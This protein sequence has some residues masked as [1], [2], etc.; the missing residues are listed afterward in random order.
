MIVPEKRRSIREIPVPE[1]RRRS[2]LSQTT[3][4]HIHTNQESNIKESLEVFKNGGLP[5]NNGNNSPRKRRNYLIASI[6]IILA[7][8][9]L[10][11]S[12]FSGAV[13]SYTPRIVT[14]SFSEDKFTAS[15]TGN[16]DLLYNVVKLSADMGEEVPASGEE[17]VEKKAS[18]V[19]TVY[20]KTAQNQRLR[21]TTR[22]A[23]PDGK[24]YQIEEAISVPAMK[25]V[26]GKETPGS[27]DVTVYS[28]K[29]GEEYNIGLSDFT[30]PGLK[31]TS[32]SE[33]VYARSQTPMS[34][35]FV[36]TEKVVSESDRL[37]AEASLETKL[38]E[39]LMSEAQKQ[40]PEGFILIPSLSAISFQA[41]PRT[42]SASGTGASVN[43]R[44]NISG[45]MFK[46][47]DLSEHL[48]VG[49]INRAFNESVEI[50]SPDS[51][52][53]SHVDGEVSEYMLSDSFEFLVTGSSEIM[54]RTDEVA[55]RADLAGR[56]K[57]ETSSVLRNYPTIVSASANIKPFWKTSFPSDP[58][59][60]NIENLHL[61]QK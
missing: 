58:K 22:F 45:V 28:E 33:S 7:L 13:L 59:R 52:T 8:A 9:F 35:G 15:K 42:P 2:G 17:S 25:V 19:I 12:F 27:L 30:L 50:L 57:K 32:L 46:L 34:G 55:L 43:L 47:V 14:V 29:A 10:A 40:T 44:A 31:G 5:P 26:N 21:A 41:L 24:V 4:T 53:F 18:G 56:H 39:S 37:R 61:K 38:R 1:G 49:K 51:L 16:G 23:T 60:I 54:W 6:V 11:I 20:N 48:S 36:G 3:P